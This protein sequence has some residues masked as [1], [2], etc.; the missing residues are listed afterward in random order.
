MKTDLRLLSS[1]LVSLLMLSCALPGLSRQSELPPG[2]VVASA[3]NARRAHESSS[4]RL[5]NRIMT[6]DRTISLSESEPL[7]WGSGWCAASHEI[8]EQNDEAIKTQLI[9]EGIQID[10][11]YYASRDYGSNDPADPTYCR[12]HYILIDSWPQGPTCLEVRLAIP[13][14]LSD[15]WDQYEPSVIAVPYCVHVGPQ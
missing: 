4:A 13:E 11:D 15:G 10:S 9:V 12:S 3:A 1:G 5:L 8:L 2:F 14:P 6:A 7:L